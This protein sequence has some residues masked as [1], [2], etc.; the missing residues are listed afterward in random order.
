MSTEQADIKKTNLKKN[1]QHL[2]LL[3]GRIIKSEQK[4]DIYMDL[5]SSTKIIW[6]YSTLGPI[7]T[8]YLFL[9]YVIIQSGVNK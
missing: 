4:N 5:K 2:I 8:L 3:V 1:V 6:I 7:W 9:I